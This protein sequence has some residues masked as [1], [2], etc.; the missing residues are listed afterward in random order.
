MAA[1]VSS[2]RPSLFFAFFFAGVFGT[3][4]CGGT[5][6]EAKAPEPVD[7]PT[8]EIGSQAPDLQINTLNGHGK[9]TKDSLAGKVIVVDF[10]A[11]N[12]KPCETTLP[13][14]QELQK[15]YDGKVEVI[16]ISADDDKANVVDWA[17]KHG[18]T[19]AIGW[20]QG[21]SMAKTWNVTKMPTTF[22]IDPQNRIRYVHNG[23]HESDIVDVSEELAH[24]SGDDKPA[25]VQVATAE[26]GGDI[27]PPM[28][29]GAPAPTA[30]NDA[31]A[32][33]AKPGK[34][35]ATPKKNS[36]KTASKKKKADG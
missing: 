36:K 6:Q 32:P 16:G 17:Q 1:S 12:C 8:L 28:G 29:K 21:H 35:A 4:A 19:F 9:V 11:S 25:Q 5:K 13:K 34:K 20:D 30:T 14:L 24:L 26:T 22:I 27:V 7:E 15:K 3:A 2:K 10:W 33:A 31:A 23:F 18:A